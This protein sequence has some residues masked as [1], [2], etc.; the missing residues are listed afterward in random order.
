MSGSVQR[1]NI[2]LVDDCD[3]DALM[4]STVLEHLKLPHKLKSFCDGREALDYLRCTGKYADRKPAMPDLLLVD[5]DMP[6]MDG[7]TLLRAIKGDKAL[8]KIP[9]IMLTSSTAREDISR[10]FECGAASYLTKPSSY[11]GYKKLLHSFGNYWLTV[12]ALPE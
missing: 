11:E 8:K 1:L 5:I 9:V 2:L 6:L 4:A 10:S 3:D 12:S 7:L